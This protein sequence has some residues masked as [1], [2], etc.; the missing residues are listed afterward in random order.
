MQNGSRFRGFVPS[1][2]QLSLDVNVLLTH[3]MPKKE[4]KVVSGVRTSTYCC[5]KGRHATG[6]Q[7]AKQGSRRRGQRIGG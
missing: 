4:K 7:G 1:P 3:F 2:S 6:H 5:P